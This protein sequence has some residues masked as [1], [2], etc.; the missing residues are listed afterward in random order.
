MKLR[1]QRVWK[2]TDRRYKGHHELVAVGPLSIIG[3]VVQFM[4]AQL[5]EQNQ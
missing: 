3:P 5:H 4:I 2:R 1:I